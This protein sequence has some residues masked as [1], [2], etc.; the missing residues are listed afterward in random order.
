MFILD[1]SYIYSSR[2]KPNSK[3]QC[4]ST[5][6]KHMRQRSNVKDTVF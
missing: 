6:F 3:Y 4:R 1:L 5:L 2:F